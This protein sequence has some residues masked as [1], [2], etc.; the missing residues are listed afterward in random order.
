M[1]AGK[2]S[3]AINIANV[4]IADCNRERINEAI[5]KLERETTAAD[6]KGRNDRATVQQTVTNIKECFNG[7][8]ALNAIGVWKNEIDVL[9]SQSPKIKEITVDSILRT[10]SF[11]LES[12]E[13]F[14][15]N[16]S[17][18]MARKIWEAQSIETQIVWICWMIWRFPFCAYRNFKNNKN[19]PSKYSKSLLSTNPMNRAGLF[20]EDFLAKLDEKTAG[21]KTGTQDDQLN[22]TQIDFFDAWFS[23][24]AHSFD[25]VLDM[26]FESETFTEDVGGMTA[27]VKHFVLKNLIEKA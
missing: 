16:D 4:R 23:D 27:E 15:S 26:L 24:P 2:T 8:E 3:I 10:G 12:P 17:D 6:T 19:M 11:A 13:T 22:E 25:P 14:V 20:A 1:A 18:M 5:D 21:M 9:I 7:P